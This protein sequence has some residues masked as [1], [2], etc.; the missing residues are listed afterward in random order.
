MHTIQTSIV[1]STVLIFICSCISLGPRLYN[2]TASIARLSVQ[3]QDES[4][5]KDAIF[6]M[7]EIEA[8]MNEWELEVGCPEKAYRLSKGIHDSLLII[9][10]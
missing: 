4:N 3:A 8:Q 7:R 1:F 9:K 5:R 10:K 2:R 6:E